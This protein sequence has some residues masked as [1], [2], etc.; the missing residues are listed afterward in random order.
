[1][2][3]KRDPTKVKSGFQEQFDRSMRILLGEGE[4]TQYEQGYISTCLDKSLNI[5]GAMLK[6]Y[7]Y[8]TLGLPTQYSD[9]GA[10]TTDYGALINLR[11]KSKHPA[12]PLIIELTELRTRQQMLRMETDP[13]GRIRSGLNEVG[14]ETGRVTSSKS[15]TGSGMNL[16]TLPDINELKPTSHLL[17]FGMRDLC[18]SDDDYLL[19]KCD[20]KGADGWTIGAN[21]ASLGDSTMLDDLRFGL[22]PA[23]FPCYARRHG[24]NSVLGLS[25]YDLGG[26][27]KEIKKSDWDYFAAKQCTWGFCYLMGLRKAADHVFEVSEG[28]VQPTESDMATFKEAIF[29]RYNVPLWHKAMERKLFNQPYPPKLLSPSGHLREFFGRKSDIVGQALAHEP[30]SVT[31]YAVN[32]AVY[33]CWTDPDNR[34]IQSGRCR[35]KVEPLHQVHDEAV[36]QFHRQD[37]EWATAKIKSWFNNEITVA[38][39]PLV[40]PFEGAYGTNWAMDEVGKI[41]DIK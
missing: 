37:T 30:Q 11:K 4:L 18:I 14:S 12:L 27:F 34:Y 40:I 19:A 1:M 5:R 29:R 16:Q 20:L 2:C 32:L 9:T 41:G 28:T 24:H 25:R 3:W 15:P 22:K 39:I 35:L 23:H 6:D 10:V 17:H 36:F 33:R 31:T 13:D 21:L 26:L 38:G 7:L 8:E